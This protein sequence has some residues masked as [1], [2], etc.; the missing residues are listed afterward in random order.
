MGHLPREVSGLPSENFL[1][2]IVKRMQ[3]ED[4]GLVSAYRQDPAT[5]AALRAISKNVA[6]VDL[7]AWTGPWGT[8]RKS[9]T[10]PAADRCRALLKRPHASMSGRDAKKLL[11]VHSTLDGEAWIVYRNAANLPVASAAE[12]PYGFTV[13]GRDE[14][15]VERRGN[16]TVVRMGETPLP[17]GSYSRVRDP[18][19][20]DPSR[21]DGLR[22]TVRVP[23]SIAWHARTYLNAFF[24]NGADPG[25]VITSPI[26]LTE[27]QVRTL[28]A[29]WEQR[30]SGPGR[31][32][33][34]AVL[35]GGLDYKQVAQPHNE[36]ALLPILKQSREDVLMVFGVPESEV[37]LTSAQ[38]YANGLSANAAFWFQTLLPL[39]L[40]IEEALNDPADGLGPRFGVYVGFN[41]AA[42]REVL[43][44]VA[45][46]TDSLTKLVGSGVPVNA[47]LDY[48]GM[49]IEPV[50]GGD[51]ALVS[52][53][54]VPLAD[55]GTLAAAAAAPAPAAPPRS[56]NGQHVRLSATARAARR[57]GAVSRV[58]RLRDAVEREVAKPTR[59]ML[60]DLRN[61]WLDGLSRYEPH[62]AAAG[63]VETRGDA[64]RVE[65]Y[66]PTQAEVEAARQYADEMTPIFERAVEEAAATVA[67]ELGHDFHTFDMTH[68]RVV[69]FVA[70]KRNRVRNIPAD[71]SNRIREAVR[72]GIERN[73]EVAELKQRVREV[74]AT[75]TSRADRIARTE[76]GDAVNG[77][78]FLTMEVEGVRRHEWS[79]FV[80][81]A[82]RQDERADHVRLDG[83]VV[84]LHGTFSNG[85]RFPNDPRGSADEVVNCR[86]VA[87]ALD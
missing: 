45:D 19:P 82:T 50:D 48:L 66:A 12:E 11:A 80:D 6:A 4:G 35:S 71:V 25:G 24:R 47:A 7:D 30:H 49:E 74:F 10:G 76:A 38:T 26:N 39:M 56:D 84:P 52:S 78:R 44:R 23:A 42:V 81:D 64:S 59:G 85:L 1:S 27:K 70:T 73:F 40:E 33:R 8:T 15:T 77:G 9:A 69:E 43:K 58:H 75:E 3:A 57:K 68:P 60:L 31:A 63:E 36:M 29:Q 67:A 20:D 86:C 62:K 83:E 61:A 79:T 18:D 5:R 21:G 87:L 13:H 53:A 16:V 41:L 14:I 2:E 32:N 54:L 55:I 46:Q 17:V 37:A 22:G 72:D 28:L 51:V 65:R 34:P